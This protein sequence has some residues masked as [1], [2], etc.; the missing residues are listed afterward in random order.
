MP[1]PAARYADPQVCPDQDVVVEP[2]PGGVCKKGSP[3]V[4]VPH[5]GGPIL[6]GSPNVNI[7]GLPAARTGDKTLCL[8]TARLDLITTGAKDVWVN[9]R[10]AA[11]A[12]T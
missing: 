6:E 5:V 9:G 3:G 7:N 10:R 4:K 8:A 11:K 1:K 12:R 2:T